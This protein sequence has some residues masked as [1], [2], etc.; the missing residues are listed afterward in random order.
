MEPKESDI[1]SEGEKV[2][3]SFELLKK[4]IEKSPLSFFSEADLQGRLYYHLCNEFQSDYNRI[5]LEYN[6]PVEY[7]KKKYLAKQKECIKKYAPNRI[8]STIKSIEKK[9]RYDLAILDIWKQKLLHVIEL[10]KITS[11]SDSNYHKGYEDIFLLT[12]LLDSFKGCQS[13]F[14]VLAICNSKYGVK[15]EKMDEYIDNINQTYKKA[16][17][18]KNTKKVYFDYYIFDKS[19]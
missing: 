19:E 7:D 2:K 4:D 15:K 17:S 14:F 12:D 13:Y 16:N 1:K 9:G 3:K 10:K 18:D 6:P 11:Y 5:H 8:Q